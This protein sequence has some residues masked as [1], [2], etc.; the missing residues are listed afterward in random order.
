MTNRIKELEN[1]ILKARD[2]YYNGQSKISDKAYDAMLDELGELDPKNI[3]ITNIGAELVSNWKKY[4][5]KKILGSL[6]KA[7][8]A[9]E[10][11]TWHNKYI[12]KTDEV[13]LTLKLDGLSVSL[14]Y[15]NGILVIGSTR[16][17]GGVTG[18]N[19]TCNVAKMIGVPLRLKKK[20]DITVRGEMVLSKDNL[21]KFFATYSNTRNAASG[22]SRKY[23]GEGCDKLTVLSYQL[24]S[25]DL[26]LKTQEDQF[27]QL[28]DL[29]FI[30]PT[31]YVVKTAKEVLDMKEKYHIKLREDF[32]FDLDGLVT[33]INNLAKQEAFGIL[34]G[35]PYSSIA[36]KFDSVAREGYI[37]DIII[38]TGSMGRLTPV[39]I[40]N[41]KI[42]L[43]GAEV[44]RASLHNFSNIANLGIDIGATVL[45][46]RS[47]DVIPFIEEVTQSTGTVFQPP[48]HCPECGVGSI[49]NG[50]YYQ[51]PNVAMCPAQKVGR[52]ANWIKELNVLEW[53]STLLEKLVE[54]GLVNT[55]ADLYTLSVDDLASL[56]RMG[57]RS[58]QKA[59]DL[60]WENVDVPLEIFLGGLSI[61]LIGQSTIKAI[62]AA[63]CDSLE[64]FGQ[65]GAAN[66][67]HVIGVGPGRANS[68]ADGLKN[69]QQ[70]I[71]DLI[72][73]GVK[74]KLKQKNISGKLSNKTFVFTGTLSIK[75]ADASKKVIDEGG[76]VQDRVTEGL[77][78]LVISDPSSTSS[79]AQKARKMGIKLISED[80]F[81]DLVK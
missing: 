4:T 42:S 72:A 69:N 73:N 21:N 6:N 76:I 18:E 56:D 5:H 66:F 62:M 45:V 74:V 43:M 71:I 1:K 9:E 35:R 20:I 81:L 75:R 34:N 60:L 63:G 80:E 52:L 61:P 78:Y 19:I 36:I 26:D 49:E 58:A 53:G 33:H 12:S 25:D 79:K 54:S 30:V 7:Q 16:G 67:E 51:C 15:E 41:P 24:I 70:L 46:C 27:I 37:S 50:E 64:K 14:V 38:Q 55:I 57:K 48:T 22:I 39:A 2:S 17:A 47:N 11:T 3:A 59:Y 68:L 13:F 31:Y 8:T 29:G 28:Q 65:L 44:E 23:D 10:Y 40:F 77:D 32:A